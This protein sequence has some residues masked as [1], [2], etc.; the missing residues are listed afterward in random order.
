MASVVEKPAAGCAGAKLACRSNSTANGI[1]TAWS[2]VPHPLAAQQQLTVGG[3]RF[4]ANPSPQSQSSAS[5]RSRLLLTVLLGLPLVR[6]KC[7]LSVTNAQPFPEFPRGRRLCP[8]SQPPSSS[9]QH[10]LARTPAGPALARELLGGNFSLRRNPAPRARCRR[11]I[12]GPALR[13]PPRAP[14]PWPPHVLRSPF[15]GRRRHALLFPASAPRSLES[16]RKNPPKPDSR[17]PEPL[18]GSGWRESGPPF[19]PSHA[20]GAIDA[21]GP[22]PGDQRCPFPIHLR[23]AFT[24]RG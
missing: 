9:P 19:T 4:P 20:P 2:L 22:S 21:L 14:R 8:R 6:R 17:Q 15:P 1:T 7:T 18:W 3:R 5:P 16:H 12:S 13:P 24:R 23:G 11:P 10:A